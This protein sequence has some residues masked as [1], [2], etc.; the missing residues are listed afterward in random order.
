MENYGPIIA[1]SRKIGDKIGDYILGDQD[2]MFLNPYGAPSFEY[3]WNDSRPLQV[4][5]EYEDVGQRCDALLIHAGLHNKVISE[6]HGLTR[7]TSPAKNVLLFGML[8]FTMLLV[9]LD[10]YYSLNTTCAVHSLACAG[11]KP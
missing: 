5:K 10:V 4:N 8:F 7:K 1:F 2:S 11:G 3:K 9:F 6:F